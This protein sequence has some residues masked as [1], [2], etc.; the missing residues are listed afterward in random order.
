M[1]IKWLSVCIMS[2]SFAVFIPSSFAAKALF[3]YKGEPAFF[4]TDNPSDKKSYLKHFPAWFDTQGSRY[5]VFNPKKLA[6]AIYDEQ[7][8]KIGA[9]KA[10]GGALY[11]K[12]VGRSCK[13]VRGTFTIYSKASKHHR[14]SK[15]PSPN[16]GA[17]MPYAMH[18]YKGYAIHGS[19][20]LPNIN[21]SHGCIRVENETAGWLSKYFVQ[22]SRTKV[23]VL[24]YK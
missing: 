12:D 23:L 16:G 24:K 2:I 21:A 17:P 14:S 3:Y 8:K 10:V 22:S 19:N 4:V 13:T 15:Y 7:G 20:S 1:W 6:F 9:G 11:C 5:L 18:F